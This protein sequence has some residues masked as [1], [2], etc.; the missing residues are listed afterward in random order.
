MAF[1]SADT[2]A[3]MMAALME[4]RLAVYSVDCLADCVAYSSVDCSE[5]S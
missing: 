5:V 4:H 1:L 2:K 3:A